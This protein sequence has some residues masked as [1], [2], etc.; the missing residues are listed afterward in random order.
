MCISVSEVKNMNM[1]LDEAIEHCEEV[2]KENRELFDKIGNSSYDDYN[3]LDCAKAHEQLAEWLKEL[4]EHK[5]K[6]TPKLV[7]YSGDGYADGKMVYD[8]AECPNC[9]FTFEE[10]DDD[11]ETKYCPDCGQALKWEEEE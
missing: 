7:I 3:C 8:W 4:K 1:T 5:E 2:A 9:S 11:W 6:D 10:S